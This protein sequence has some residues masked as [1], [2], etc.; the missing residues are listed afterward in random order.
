MVEATL[1][2][3]GIFFT[4]ERGVSKVGRV[5]ESGT[6]SANYSDQHFLVFER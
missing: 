4:S 2:F 6:V 3:D 1:A 5:P